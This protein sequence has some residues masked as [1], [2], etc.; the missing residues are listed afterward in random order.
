MCRALAQP[1]TWGRGKKA[2]EFIAK[3][4]KEE[5]EKKITTY[6]RE[7]S[8]VRK[9][10]LSPKT[11]ELILQEPDPIELRAQDRII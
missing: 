9:N 8:M 2:K 4:K 10:Q 5:E 1:G 11:G 3:K 6:M 7:Q